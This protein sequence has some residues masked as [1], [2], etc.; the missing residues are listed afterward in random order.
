MNVL[1][2]LFGRAVSG[3]SVVPAMFHNGQTLD[4]VLQARQIANYAILADRLQR[5]LDVS[6]SDVI[7]GQ[8]DTSSPVHSAT[9]LNSF[10]AQQNVAEARPIELLSLSDIFTGDDAAAAMACTDDYVLRTARRIAPELALRYEAVAQPLMQPELTL[11]SDLDHDWGSP[12][13]AFATRR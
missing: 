12:A 9:G 4:V 5:G 2:E 6:A 1:S 8:F 13:P 10:I 7:S 3:R 11:D